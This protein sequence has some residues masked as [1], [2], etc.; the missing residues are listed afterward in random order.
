MRSAV[1]CL[2]LHAGLVSAQY[3]T[4]Q[5]MKKVFDTSFPSQPRFQISIS[6]NLQSSKP[7][8]SPTP[9]RSKP[10]ESIRI[11]K[12]TP[13]PVSFTFI[14]TKE[15]REENKRLL[16]EGRPEKIEMLRFCHM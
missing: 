8:L 1:T 6:T 10:M 12:T 14:S 4:L 2:T 13:R 11:L 5:L 9:T 7:V 3:P 16:T 15:K